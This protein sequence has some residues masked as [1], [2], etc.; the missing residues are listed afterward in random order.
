MYTE[1]NFKTKKALKEA[2]EAWVEFNN[3]PALWT[4]KNRGMSNLGMVAGIAPREPSPVRYYQPGPFGGNVQRDGT[5]CVEGPHYP[6]PHKWYATC[7]AK[8]GVI[9]KVK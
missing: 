5:F 2:V 4:L 6:E 7:T 8:D 9:I 1:K 3:N